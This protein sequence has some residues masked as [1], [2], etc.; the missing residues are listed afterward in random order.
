MLEAVRDGLVAAGLRW[1]EISSYARPGREAVHNQ[2]Y[3]RRAPVLGIGVGA[4]STEVAGSEAP[5]GA[6]SANERDLATWL[7]RVEGKG[8]ADPPFR[9]R[10]SAETARA[11]TAFLGLRTARGLVAAEFSARFG[12]TPRALFGEAIEELCA[13][14]LLRE[15]DAGDL[16]LSRAGWLVA[17]AVAA[18][19]V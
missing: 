13:A 12:A 3:W 16:C 15:S 1:Y 5:H 7:R 6:R 9:E 10:L 2:R 4:H 18:R 11:E 8:A 17:D 14:G 19:F